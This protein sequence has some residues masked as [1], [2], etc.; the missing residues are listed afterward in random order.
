M[1]NNYL[2][3]YN[4]LEEFDAGAGIKEKELFTE[5]QQLSFLPKKGGF[6]GAERLYSNIINNND[7]K[8]LLALIMLVLAI[9]SNSLVALIF[10]ILAAIF[11]P[12]PALIIA[13]CIAV[14]LNN[15]E[16]SY[17]GISI[18]LMVASA[19]TIYLTSTSRISKGFKTTIDIIL[20]VI[21]GFYI[22]KIYGID[23]QVAPNSKCNKYKSHLESLRNN[24]FNMNSM[25]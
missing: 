9:N 7:L 5:E 20:L 11:V 17:I 12:V 8:S 24:A 6:D 25:L 14:H 1:N 13:Y 18:L 22:V 16:G 15:T 19:V 10:I 3:Y 23:K 2:N 4:V 21:L